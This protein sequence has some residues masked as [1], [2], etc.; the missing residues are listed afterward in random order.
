MDDRIDGWTKGQR[1]GLMVERTDKRSK[2]GKSTRAL[3]EGSK[4][5]ML[6]ET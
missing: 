5:G 6:H 1:D 4:V 2:A 3:L